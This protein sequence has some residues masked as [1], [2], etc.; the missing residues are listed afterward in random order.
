MLRDVYI[1]VSTA[2]DGVEKGKEVKPRVN[3]NRIEDTVMQ[4]LGLREDANDATNA[5]LR[6]RPIP[7]EIEYPADIKQP[8]EIDGVTSWV[9]S[10]E[11]LFERK[12]IVLSD[13]RMMRPG[14]YIIPP[15]QRK[16][17]W[18]YENVSQLCRDLLRSADEGQASYHLGTII[19]HHQPGGQGN[20]FYVVDGQQRLTTISYL[21]NS[22][23][24]TVDTAPQKIRKS[25]I[26][27]I[28][29]ALEEYQDEKER[30]LEQLKRR[31]RA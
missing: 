26:R 31:L 19:L 29:G 13:G 28:L 16:Y 2:L 5:E 11:A 24:F 3:Q 12:E 17:T 30:I 21:I 7:Q 23:I 15:Y 4:E 27:S 10:I 6:L 9:T 20:S 8:N 1:D 25:D 14:N 18:S 22:E